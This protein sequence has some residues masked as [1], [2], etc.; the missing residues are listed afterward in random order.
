MPHGNGLDMYH[1]IRR[2]NWRD[3]LEGKLGPN[4]L[5]TEP[6]NTC[7]LRRKVREVMARGEGR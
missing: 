2:L 4:F 1:E 7:E 3:G 6:F 5:P